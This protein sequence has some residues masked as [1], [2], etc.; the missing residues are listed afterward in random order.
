MA[1]EQ[2]TA[3]PTS[4][5]ALN[6]NHDGTL[7]AIASSYTFEEG[8]KEY[9]NISL[10]LR[11]IRV[12]CSHPQDSVFIRTISESEVKPKL[13]TEGPWLALLGRSL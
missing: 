10:L 7:L 6:F 4:I 11:L 1:R 9:V 2:Y 3:Y 12:L 13:K 8:E 5:A